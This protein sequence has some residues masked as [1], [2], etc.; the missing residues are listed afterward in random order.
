[1]RHRT[2]HLEPDP[3]CLHRQPT[4]IDHG[5]R[6]QHENPSTIRQQFRGQHQCE[7]P[8]QLHR[9]RLRHCGGVDAAGHSSRADCAWVSTTEMAGWNGIRNGGM[10]LSIAPAVEIRDIS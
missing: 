2:L 8:R 5:P 7:H 3:D 10:R 1:M 4:G 9:N 6:A